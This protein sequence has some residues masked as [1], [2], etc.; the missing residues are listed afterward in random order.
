MDQNLKLVCKYK[1]KGIYN[2]LKKYSMNMIKFY[3]TSIIV[4]FGILAVIIFYSKK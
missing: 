1:F 4:L 2:D 3:G